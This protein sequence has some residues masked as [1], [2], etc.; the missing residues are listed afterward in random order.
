MRSGFTDKL[1]SV[2]E[3]GQHQH[4]DHDLASVEIAI[5][6]VDHGIF[7]AD[8]IS[9]KMTHFWSCITIQEN[10]DRK[11]LFTPKQEFAWKTS[12]GATVI[13]YLQW[14]GMRHEFNSGDRE[15]IKIAIFSPSKIGF[16]ARNQLG[17]QK[18]IKPLMSK[19]PFNVLSAIFE[20]TIMEVVEAIEK[21]SFDV[22]TLEKLQGLNF[23]QKSQS[24]EKFTVDAVQNLEKPILENIV[25]KQFGQEIIDLACSS[26]EVHQLKFWMNQLNTMP[27]MFKT[28]EHLLF[29]HCLRYDFIQL[30]NELPNPCLARMLQFVASKKDILSKE[31]LLVLG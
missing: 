22:N 7:K 19:L 3:E 28:Y 31:K 25:N 5:W 17:L 30:R 9:L 23:I 11:L 8:Q 4:M 6:L 13:K 26:L 10:S 16:D 1:I 2:A 21:E 14:L 20:A 27:E 15:L 29:R 18:C 12:L 24:S